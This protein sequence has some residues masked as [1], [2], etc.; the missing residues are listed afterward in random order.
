MAKILSKYASLPDISQEIEFQSQKDYIEA[1]SYNSTLKAKKDLDK[2]YTFREW[3]NTR[4]NILP[5]QEY[6]LYNQYLSQWYE[7]RKSSSIS[8]TINTQDAYIEILNQLKSSIEDIDEID[9]DDPA[10]I[11]DNIPVFSKKIKDITHYFIA[12]KESLRKSKLK[13]NMVGTNLGLER[14]FYEYLLKAFTQNE[15]NKIVSTEGIPELSAAQN[16]QVMIEDLY[17]D[18]TYFDRDPNLP[19]SAYFI[20]TTTST[21]HLTSHGLTSDD[22]D[23]LYNTGVSQLC[24]DNPLLWAVDEVLSLYNNGLP[25]S[26]IEDTTTNILNDYNRINLTK[27]YLGTD[28]FIISGGY[29][30]LPTDTLTYGISAGNNWFYWPSGSVSNVTS[31]AKYDDLPLSATTLSSLGYASSSYQTADVIFVR[32]GDDIKG[33]WLQSPNI[34]TEYS[35]M[36]AK[37]LASTSNNFAY[38]FPGYGLSGDDIEWTGRQYSNLDYTCLFLN[39]EIKKQIADLYWKTKLPST[40]QISSINIHETN[41]IS[42]GAT[43]GSDIVA[44]DVILIRPSLNTNNTVYNNS[45]SG[46]WLYK[47]DSTNIIIDVGTNNIL[48]PYEKFDTTSIISEKLDFSTVCLD[49][50][51]SSIPLS[52][53]NQGVTAVEYDDADVIYKINNG[54]ETEAAYLSSTGFIKLDYQNNDWVSLST[55]SDMIIRPG[56]HIKYIHRDTKT[57]GTSSI[58][59]SA[60]SLNISL[61]GWNYTTKSFD[62]TS[63]GIRPIWVDIVIDRVPENL[64]KGYD[65]WGG[66][67]IVSGDNYIVHPK[68]SNLYLSGDLPIEYYN[69]GNTFIWTQLIGKTTYNYN[70]PQWKKLDL[71]T[72]TIPSYLP[73]SV[74]QLV[75]S[76]SND[77]SDIIF[78]CAHDDLQSVNYF[79]TNSF[80]WNQEVRDSTLGLPPTGGAWHAILSGNLVTAEF[81]AANLTN[82]HYPTYASVPY[83][84]NIHSTKDVGGYMTPKGLGVS[85]ALTRNNYNILET[86]GQTD[87]NAKI[88]QNIETYNNDVGL[89]KTF[90]NTPVSTV[91]VDSEWMKCQFIEGNQAGVIKNPGIYQEFVPYQS[92]FESY[93]YKNKTGILQQQDT[94]DQYTIINESLTGS[95][96][97]QWDTDIFGNQ[98]GLYQG[99]EL[100]LWVRNLKGEASPSIESLINVY[101]NLIEIFDTKMDNSPGTT[102]SLIFS[103][104]IKGFKIFYDTILFILDNALVMAK[105]DIDWEDG[106]IFTTPNDVNIIKIEDNMKYVDHYFFSDTKS[107]T[108]GFLINCDGLTDVSTQIRPLLFSLDLN[109]NDLRLIYNIDSTETDFY[110]SGLTTVNDIDSAALTYDKIRLIYN[111]SFI[112]K[113]PSRGMYLISINIRQRGADFELINTKIIEPV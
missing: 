43:P 100:T 30:T 110:Y 22:F 66:N 64:Y 37:L 79:A 41:L 33:A 50:N 1:L 13:Y 85:T 104:S 69:K 68:V 95:E 83:I 34:G 90:Q 108:L 103:Q 3:Y 88:F 35:Y 49:I 8:T 78:Q 25:L 53:W 74:K 61:S 10:S 93:H 73:I 70:A 109:T 6:V 46:A 59:A 62:G 67:A 19:V 111:I 20:N 96:L 45:L 75:V 101:E 102:T 54:V 29:Y 24:A 105:L 51:L 84:D 38:P 27:K 5:G 76:G 112:Y 55:I 94:F 36:S 60:F 11:V 42:Q 97:I 48:W 71:S 80:I 4:Y 28:Q 82:R 99:S 106:S 57:I 72:D 52:T 63:S 17:D 40:E 113:D 9:I 26:A 91:Q 56:D 47:L 32:K 16:L 44:A 86:R 81:P 107:V 31:L 89:T 12:K 65:I 7:D 15:S 2:P 18:S 14:L 39:K 87:Q 98:Y 92:T 77:I 58:E 23:W 21:E